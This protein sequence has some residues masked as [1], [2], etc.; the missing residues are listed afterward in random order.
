MVFHSLIE[1]LIRFFM[2]TTLRRML[3]IRQKYRKAGIQTISWR[4]ILPICCM[5]KSA[6]PLIL[7]GLGAI[8]VQV[9]L[10]FPGLRDSIYPALKKTMKI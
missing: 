10:A 9:R 6:I 5:E 3:H 2:L 8:R 7:C 1:R 4:S